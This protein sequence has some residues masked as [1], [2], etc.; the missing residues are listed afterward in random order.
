M[1]SH[2]SKLNIFC[3]TMTLV[4][5]T[6]IQGCGSNSIG[7]QLING[8]NVSTT[9]NGHDLLVSVSAD[10]NIGNLVFPSINLPITDPKH[11]LDPYVTLILQR[12]LCGKN[13][14][15]VN[16][17]VANLTT[18]LP[19]G[20]Q[21]VAWDFN[22]TLD[23]ATRFVESRVGSDGV[24]RP[25]TLDLDRLLHHEERHSQQ[26]AHNGH[27]GMLWALT[28]DWMGLERDAGL[29]DGGYEK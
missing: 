27:L 23:G 12:T 3:L 22:F 29:S 14:L 10:L 19:T 13:V 7:S 1:Q 26:W 9:P 15:T 2:R 24:P 17:E 18:S 6:A 8:L 11:P 20:A 4:A 28:S 25:G 5:I 16:I 21:S